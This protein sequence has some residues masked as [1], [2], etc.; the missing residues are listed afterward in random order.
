MIRLLRY[1]RS[2]LIFSLVVTFL[3]LIT[4]KKETAIRVFPRALTGEVTD[5]S[6]D[7]IRLH[8]EILAL[9]SEPVLDHGF[10]ISQSLNP[11]LNNGVV[12]S[13][14]PADKTGPFE[15]YF[16]LVMKESET[17]YVLSYLKTKSYLVYGQRR[18]F[19]SPG[20]NNPVITGFY[21][22]AGT[23]GDTIHI[24]GQLFADQL[25]GNV[26][27]FDT[28][29]APVLHVTDTS[30]TVTVPATLQKKQSIITV[31]TFGNKTQSHDVFLLQESVINT[32]EPDHGFYKDTIDIYGAYFNS[33]TK[34]F[35]DTIPADI[36]EFSSDH[37]KFKVPL[38]F[39]EGYLSIKVSTGDMAVV[40]PGVFYYSAPF[41]GTI[42]PGKGT[43]RDTLTMTGRNFHPERPNRKITM[44]NRSCAVIS[45][46]DTLIRFLIPDRAINEVPEIKF[47]ID[48]AS[49][50]VHDK[51]QGLFLSVISKIYPYTLFFNPSFPVILLFIDLALLFF[52]FQ[53]QSFN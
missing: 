43:F 21:P 28:T 19:L 17:Y 39:T 24:T 53:Y 42:N 27:W 40:K 51:F 38:F 47:F 14:G 36:I 52:L 5:I 37:I 16:T 25:N 7:G 20:S 31:E 10:V 44:D 12:I 11:R 49:F 32:I 35:V 4:C 6:K 34:V 1:K 33:Y 41:F 13:L 15:A 18:S 9:G 26:V 22:Q 23:W 48:D 8:G 3:L 50:P 30:L 45:Y 46:S 2:I 29:K